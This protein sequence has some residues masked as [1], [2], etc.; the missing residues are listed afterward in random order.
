[1]LQVTPNSR[2]SPSF[3]PIAQ[4]DL[5]SIPK[6]ND[7]TLSQIERQHYSQVQFWNSILNICMKIP[8]IDLAFV[9]LWNISY[10]HSFFFQKTP[11]L[12]ETVKIEVP[13]YFTPKMELECGK[14]IKKVY[15]TQLQNYI[16]RSPCD[17]NEFTIFSTLPIPKPCRE[18]KEL[19]EACECALQESI[20]KFIAK[21]KQNSPKKP[22]QLHM[23]DLFFPSPPSFIKAFSS[24]LEKNETPITY[25]HI[26]GSFEKSEDFQTLLQAI[27]E[28]LLHNHFLE[29]IIIQ[30]QCFR[31]NNIIEE[32]VWEGL[33]MAVSL[34][35]NLK[36]L[37]FF[38]APPLPLQLKSLADEVGKKIQF[39]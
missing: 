36:T 14:E 18:D 7:P 17:Q 13:S 9:Y 24:V 16:L 29:T 32:M 35:E 33:L 8:F 23:G 2:L 39:S 5:P 19:R 10:T 31:K 6:S 1:M 3:F 15:I 22:I 25:L 21:M 30:N 4:E 27:V 34:H 38:H 12:L 37:H 11:S 28:N 20:T 26:Q